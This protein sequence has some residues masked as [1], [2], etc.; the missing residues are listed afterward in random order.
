MSFENVQLKKDLIK[1]FLSFL[2]LIEGG[3]NVD[4]NFKDMFEVVID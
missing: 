4:N 1:I 3:V 2:F